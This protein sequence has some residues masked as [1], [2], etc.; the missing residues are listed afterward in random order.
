MVKSKMTAEK[1][2]INISFGNCYEKPLPKEDDELFFVL[3]GIDLAKN[4]C[5]FAKRVMDTQT[6][7]LQ[8]ELEKRRNEQKI[9]MLSE[10]YQNFM[11]YVCEVKGFPKK[12]RAELYGNW[13]R[14]MIKKYEENQKV[15]YKRIKEET[16]YVLAV[17]DKKKKKMGI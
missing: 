3:V 5:K 4:S 13:Y 17:N 16:Y 8:S 6:F 11:E 12:D 2:L 10:C 1:K 14:M 7:S 9:K 15:W